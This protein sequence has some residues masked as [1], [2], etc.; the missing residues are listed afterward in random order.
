M[1]AAFHTAGELEKLRAGRKCE[2]G[3]KRGSWRDR[4]LAAATEA[5]LLVYLKVLAS[6]IVE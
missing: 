1:T 5:V 2:A 3:A 6:F 4:G